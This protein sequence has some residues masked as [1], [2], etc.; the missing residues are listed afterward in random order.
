MPVELEILTGPETGR[1]IG[2]AP[3]APLT[4]GWGPDADL[5]VP[6]DP[7]MNPVHAA[8]EWDGA[9]LRV[10]DLATEHGTFV[11]NAA[12]REVELREGDRVQMGQTLVQVR[13][14]DGADDVEPGH[15][16]YLLAER[17][18]FDD[19]L[20]H[21]A[22]FLRQHPYDLFAIIDAARDEEVLAFLQGATEE[23]VSLYEGWQGE[24][25]ADV[26]PYLVRV[27]REGTFLEELLQRGWSKSWGV[28]VTSEVPF[29]ALRQHLRYFLRVQDEDGNRML[30][31]FYDPRV[32]R[33]YLPTCTPYETQTFFGPI[34]AF[35]FE[36]RRG[37]FAIHVSPTVD[38]P[39]V[40]SEALPEPM[41]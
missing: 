38:G 10:R 20:Q 22:W 41:P 24:S 1:R 37:E 14:G 2:V 30:F 25:L 6:R 12:V 39:S 7:Y 16:P 31:R 18:V 27:P 40:F 8:F 34:E 17:P 4:V 28:F 23:F 33:A 5:A 32:L 3:G 26:A 13:A 19:R 21:V 9:A 29:K 11:N 36:G 15:P 35:V